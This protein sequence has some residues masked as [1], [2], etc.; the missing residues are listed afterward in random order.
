M[1]LKLKGIIPLR[2]FVIFAVIRLAIITLM[3]GFASVVAL[4]QT[5][6]H[7]K[8]NQPRPLE[9]AL[10]K[11]EK[12]IGVPINYEDPRFACPA[13][14]TDVT[15]TVQSAA[16]RA[17]NPNTRIIVPK[18]GPL[19]LDTSVPAKPQSSDA[20]AAVTLLRVQHEARG[21]P[22]RFSVK[23]V[24]SVVTVEPNAV[25]TGDCKWE[26]ATPAMETHISF[27]SQARAALDTLL[28]I[29]KTLEQH[30]GIK[31]G[32]ANLPMVAFANR[33]V[34]VGADNEPANVVLSHLFEQLSAPGLI[35]YS[36]HM[37]YDPGL[38][39]YMVDIGAVQP[40]VAASQAATAPTSPPPVGA[41]GARPIKE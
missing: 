1:Y 15:A 41:F 37:F 34:T 31:V 6:V 8:V 32:L 28:L 7:I 30:I 12:A 20:L 24:G 23:Q 38:K 9:A 17:A 36:Y 22:G 11:L 26:G 14:V 5:A 3:S 25:R 39:F 33:S 2:F 35:S 4:A 10:D 13:D 16:Q 18:G 29:L 21:Y 19:S 27:P 40:V